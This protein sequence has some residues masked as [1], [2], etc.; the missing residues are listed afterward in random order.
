MNTI[1]LH[2]SKLTLGMVLLVK[3]MIAEVVFAQY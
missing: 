1:G 2:S 3:A